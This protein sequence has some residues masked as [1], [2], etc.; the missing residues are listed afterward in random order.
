MGDIEQGHRRWYQDVTGYQWLVL[1]IASLGWIFDVFEGQIFVASRNEVMRALLRP[2]ASDGDI[3]YYGNIAYGAFLVGGALGGVLFGML[4][5]R[6]GRQLTMIFTILMYSAFTCISA[7]SVSWWD[8]ACYR[9]LVGLGVGG[10]WAVASALVAEVFAQRARAWS[11]SIFHASSVLGSY[12]AIAA[13]VL[14]IGNP[15][16]GWRWGFVVGVLPALLTV[17]VRASLRESESWLQAR[18]RTA[19]DLRQKLGSV[20]GLFEPGLAR[21]TLLGVGLATVGLATFWG[22][23]IYG[24]DMMR[25]AAMNQFRA[26]LPDD[27][28]G[29]E[30]DR[31]IQ[32]QQ[33]ALKQAEM[34]GM[35]LVTSGGGLGLVCF[36]PICEWLGRRGAFLI[37]QLGGLAAS[38]VL[39]QVAMP[40][41]SLWGLLPIFGF[42]T[43][44]MHAGFAVYFPELFPTRLRGTGAGFCFNVGRLTAAPILFLT[45]WMQKDWHFSL[46]ES[47]SLLSLL[48]LAGSALLLLAPETRGRDL[49]A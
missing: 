47:A 43:L 11:L 24:K 20:A 31:A 27:M 30:R 42:L 36:A 32:G 39:F 25:K 13:G 6:I 33:P 17:W 8:M 29:A 37:F 22:T 38:L 35:F 28:P 23:H 40:D 2:E 3:A 49:A 48:F 15:A 1:T 19:A 7:F 18:Q 45:G 4:S 16:I 41:F 12:L 9:F 21:R 44:G 14:L 10:E 34:I 26:T 46:E 5:D